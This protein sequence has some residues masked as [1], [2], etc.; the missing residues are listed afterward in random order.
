MSSSQVL[1]TETK[2][3]SGSKKKKRSMK[4]CIFDYIA[5]HI[6]CRFKKNSLLRSYFLAILP[7]GFKDRTL[8]NNKFSCQRPKNKRNSIKKGLLLKTVAAGIHYGIH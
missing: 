1:L 3:T 2:L 6:K 5:L 8:Q 4:E 7:A